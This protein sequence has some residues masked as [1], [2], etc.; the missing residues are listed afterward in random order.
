MSKRNSKSEHPKIAP[1]VD[2]HLA[3]KEPRQSKSIDLQVVETQTPVWQLCAMDMDADC[4]WSWCHI[5]KDR[6]ETKVLPKLRDFE[7]MTWF[8]IERAS[9]GRTNGTN[10]HFIDVRQLSK[11]AQKHL[12]RLKMDDLDQVFSL[13][14]QGE[15]RIIGKRMGRVLQIIWFDFHHEV[16]LSRKK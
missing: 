2:R 8:E 16:C 11:E 5:G 15:H 6:W 1:T 14:L 13:R 7:K 10:S 3:E 9:G 4:R 12:E